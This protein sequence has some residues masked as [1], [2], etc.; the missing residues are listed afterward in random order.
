MITHRVKITLY[1]CLSMIIGVV[2]LLA[3]LWTPDKTN[4]ELKQWLLPESEFVAAQGMQVHV[5]QSD[6][7][8]KIHNKTVIDDAIKA[9]LTSL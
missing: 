9:G 5:V 7:C 4:A 1:V 6:L 8:R 3:L 2:A